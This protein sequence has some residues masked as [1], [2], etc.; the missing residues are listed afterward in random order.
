MTVY[1]SK[2]QQLDYLKDQKLLSEEFFAASSAYKEESFK[3]D[4][5]DLTNEVMKLKGEDFKG[6]LVDMRN[7][8]YGV[9]PELQ[10]WH[11]D[12]VY[13]K[14]LEVGINKMAIVT[15]PDV[16]AAIS[17]EQTFDEYK[18][19]TLETQY[20]KDPENAKEWLLS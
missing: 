11:K 2:F 3:K 15:S 8:R 12:E 4:F 14:I 19:G 5:I 13:P 16:F 6:I 18:E 7:F 20:F 9:L 17:T 1:K 10:A